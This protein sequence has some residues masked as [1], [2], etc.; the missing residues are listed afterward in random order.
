MKRLID[1]DKLLDETIKDRDYAEENE[2]WDMYYERQTLIDRINN[3]PTAY[4]IDKVVKQL[5]ERTAFL[6][7]LKYENDTD[8]SHQLTKC[9][10]TMMIYKVIELVDDLIEIVKDG[11]LE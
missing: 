9:Y 6:N 3:Q 2:I 5:E 1:A 7:D 11:G 10:G 8:S 4:D